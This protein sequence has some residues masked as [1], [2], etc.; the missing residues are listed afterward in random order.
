MNRPRTMPLTLD[1]R[2]ILNE[3]P[4]A[5]L[6]FRFVSDKNFLEVSEDPHFK[7]VDLTFR[8]WVRYWRTGYWILVRAPSIAVTCEYREVA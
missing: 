8:N 7:L 3:N 2:R 4:N 1:L 5:E 6:F